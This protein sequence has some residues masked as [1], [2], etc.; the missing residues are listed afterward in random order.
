M[1]SFGS[2]KMGEALQRI[3][4]GNSSL[5]PGEIGVADYLEHVKSANEKVPN[6]DEIISS[7]EE[8]L[9]NIAG[10]INRTIG[11]IES[12]Q[13]IQYCISGRDLSQ[14]NG[15]GKQNN[16]TEARFPNLLNQ[17][18]VMIAM[19]A[20][21]KAQDN[22]NKKLNDEISKA[23]KDASTDIAQYMCQMLPSGG[24]TGL[25]NSVQTPLNAPYAI[26][27]DVGSGLDLKSLT[28]GGQSSSTF[29][30]MSTTS[31]S[32]AAGAVAGAAIGAAVSPVGMVVGAVAGAALG[33]SNK[34]TFSIP[35]GTKTMW[36][37]FNRETRICRLCTNMSTQSCSSKKNWFRTNME[38][39][40]AKIEESCQDIPM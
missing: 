7:I 14:I 1:I 19:S 33:A 30:G 25:D 15:K 29:G 38:C 35:G 8:E 16:S 26:S 23:T 6:K 11:L 28:G 20:L 4:D 10:T 17:Y 39:G 12:D 40:E 21:R 31:N 36:S 37:T 24:G 18:R 22:Y 34:Q 2:I 32:A 5:K 9:N 27:Y 13:Q 3:Q